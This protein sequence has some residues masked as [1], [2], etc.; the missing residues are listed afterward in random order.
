MLKQYDNF[1]AEEEEAL[2]LAARRQALH[3]AVDIG[4]FDNI[5]DIKETLEEMWH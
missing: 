3:R 5:R 2:R 4:L 1:T